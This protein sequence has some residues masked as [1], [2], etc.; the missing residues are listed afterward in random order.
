MKACKKLLTAAIL[1]SID[2][3][4]K[5]ELVLTVLVLILPYVR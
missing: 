1:N 3:K 2:P 4:G 5:L